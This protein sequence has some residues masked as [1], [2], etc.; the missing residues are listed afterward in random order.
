[1]TSYKHSDR[2]LV[3]ELIERMI[4]ALRPPLYE[5]SLLMERT[6]PQLRTLFLLYTY[7]P[8]RMGSISCQLKVGMPTVTSLVTKL[9]EKGLVARE[10]NIQD[11]RVVLCSTTENG[12]AEV[13]RFWRVRREQIAQISDSLSEEDVEVVDRA[14]N[15]VIHA[16]ELFEKPSDKGLVS[17][18]DEK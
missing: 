8:M 16:A 2:R 11:R 12:K 4:Y 5:E 10:H 9:E 17:A 6:V 3:V 7:G 13:K 14:M 18:A 15:I 1:M